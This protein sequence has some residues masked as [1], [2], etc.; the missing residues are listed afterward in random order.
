MPAARALQLYASLDNGTVNADAFRANVAREFTEKG[1]ASGNVAARV[2]H[3]PGPD[4]PAIAMLP[5]PRPHIEL[6]NDVVPAAPPITVIPRPRPHLELATNEDWR[7]EALAKAGPV[8]FGEL[9]EV[10]LPR[11]RPRQL[12]SRPRPKPAGSSAA[13]STPQV[14]R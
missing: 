14:T 10:P 13:V 2:T 4:E 5:R 12:S 6:T 8:H 1:G 11:P 9:S 7:T 3:D